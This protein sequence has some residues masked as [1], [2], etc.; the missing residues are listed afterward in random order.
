MSEVYDFAPPRL[1]AG[2][3]LSLLNWVSDRP[4]QSYINNSLFFILCMIHD[5]EDTDKYKCNAKKAYC[6]IF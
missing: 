3:G 4:T 1:H 6:Q 5:D 2:V